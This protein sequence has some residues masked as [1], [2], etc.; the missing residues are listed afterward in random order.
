V[1]TV[2]LIKIKLV[3]WFREL[4]GC[5]VFQKKNYYRGTEANHC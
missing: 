3:L 4:F 1:T 5:W 2:R